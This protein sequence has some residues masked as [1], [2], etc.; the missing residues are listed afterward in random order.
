ME[1]NIFID[2]VVST[3]IARQLFIFVSIVHDLHEVYLLSHLVVSNYHP[4]ASKEKCEI[5]EEGAKL[6]KKI[7]V[8]IGLLGEKTPSLLL[9]LA[10]GRRRC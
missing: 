10:R 5:E 6:T 1:P 3:S 8:R 7:R 2:T 4:H 9:A